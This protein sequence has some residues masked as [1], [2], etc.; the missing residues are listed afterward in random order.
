MVIFAYRI[1]K[2]SSIVCSQFCG[3]QWELCVLGCQFVIFEVMAMAC[4]V[5]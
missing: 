1:W 2:S 3:K 4:G 5:V